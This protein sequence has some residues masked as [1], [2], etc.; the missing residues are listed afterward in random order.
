ME[1]VRIELRNWKSYRNADF[2]LPVPV[3][4]KRVI[5][6]GALNGSGKTSLLEAL[7]V[8]TYGSE[9]HAKLVRKKRATADLSIV[10]AAA[11]Y[12][13]FLASAFNN[14][15]REVGDKRMEVRTTW[16]LHDSRAACSLLRVKRSWTL[17]ARGAVEEEVSI[18]RGPSEDQLEIQVAPALEGI[19]DR[20]QYW[21][22]YIAQNLLPDSMAG[23]YFF[24]G[25]KLE[26][27]ADKSLD[28]QLLQSIGEFFGVNLLEKFENVMQDIQEDRK[29][30]Y[31][32]QSGEGVERLREE[33]Q[34][35]RSALAAADDALAQV[36]S[37]LA[38]VEEALRGVDDELGRLVR[39]AGRRP[40]EIRSDISI[41]RSNHNKYVAELVRFADLDLPIA[42]AASCLRPMLLDQL[43]QD[44]GLEQWEAERRNGARARQAFL[45]ELQRDEPR[46]EPPLTEEQRAALIAWVDRVWEHLHH[47]RPADLSHSA[48]H[49]Y[50]SAGQ[51]QSL[52]DKLPA[53]GRGAQAG[54]GALFEKLRVSAE[55]LVQLE[56]EL[57][58]YGGVDDD[59]QID[60][61][62]EQSR[63]L[64]SEQRSLDSEK[65][66]QGNKASSL[67]VQLAE[68]ER[69]SKRQSQME[70]DRDVVGK[71]A[72][73]ADAAALGRHAELVKQHL[74]RH[75]RRQLAAAIEDIYKSIAHKGV[76]TSVRLTKD[77][78][79]LLDEN[80][81]D[82]RGHDP[83]AGERQVFG[84]AIVGALH[85][86]T[87]ARAPIIIDTPLGR[88]DS[89]H[90]MRLVEWI[91]ANLGSQVIFL[92]TDEEVVGPKK[93][94]LEP[95]IATTFR[96]DFDKGTSVVRAGEYFE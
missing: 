59:G 72:L 75:Y 34:Q 90:R 36:N 92:S 29:N 37:R 85:R 9:G 84:M 17:G 54:L 35:C 47:P 5:L 77:G 67:R 49:A 55:T 1:L 28:R 70:L 25:E 81:R 19:S 14:T 16:R 50:L 24:D 61:L 15:A 41:R 22:R 10:E 13:A 95:Y 44:E 21:R 58:E 79:Q 96:V 31:G 68:V 39:A 62:Q 27:L 78:L 91:A 23:Y 88:L 56:Q 71:R 94:L 53:L 30:R 93:R 43:K 11:P 48:V 66:L 57:A 86:V 32:L 3:D 20:R 83:S 46:T 8:G 60:R 12:H 73:L 52:L 45:D 89:S 7:L 2:R 63:N 87:N 65:A 64:V 38:E 6:I 18:E 74:L 26:H 42:M 51:R 69:R 40:Q 4:G 76:A 80:G 82:L 33:E